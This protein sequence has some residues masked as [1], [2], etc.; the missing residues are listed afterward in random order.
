MRKSVFVIFAF[1]F[2]V[3][4]SGLP[5]FR[6]GF[7]QNYHARDTVAVHAQSAGCEAYASSWPQVAHDP[8]HT[9]YIDEELI[10]TNPSSPSFTVKWVHAFQP[11]KVYPQVQPI[12]YCGKV[13]VGTEGANG[14]KPTVYAFDAMSVGKNMK[15]TFET[16]GPIMASAAGANGVVVIADMSGTVYGLNAETGSKLWEQ[17]L[18]DRH[19]FS[20]SPVISD[21]SIMIG[22][23]NG[24]LYVL[25]LDG[26]IPSGWQDGLDLHTPLLQTPAYANG[27]LYIG[28]MDLKMYAIRIA[29]KSIVWESA[30]M[31]GIALNDYWPIITNNQL[32]IRPTPE[33][34]FY[35]V[36]QVGG[37]FTWGTSQAWLDQYATTLAAGNLLD[38]PAANNAQTTF[39]ANV[40][41]NPNS[42]ANN[43]YVLDISDG[44]IAT[45][46]PFWNQALNGANPP[47]CYDGLNDYLVTPVTF[48]RGTFG[49]LD[50]ASRKIVDILFDNKDYNGNLLTAT[51]EPAGSG[52]MDET[53]LCSVSK[54]LVFTL[55]TQEANA[56]YTGAFDL[57]NRR[58]IKMPAGHTDAAMRSN[59]QG[60][61]G[62][63]ASIAGGKIYH[64]SLNNLIVR[65]PQ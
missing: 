44:S 26:T 56:Y 48:I 63:P 24:R 25:N 16:L 34:I 59:T 27:V 37:P 10:F 45:R 4:I 33:E 5:Y 47:P 53:V 31:Q 19:G 49:R 13:I 14:Q 46:V 3:F 61:G 43:F 64:L 55:H 20:A 42:F 52:N 8:Q 36:S 23:R 1:L 39:L 65:S 40:D 9:G 6:E 30:R 7:F 32:V 11:D 50:L 22:G 57:T 54:N 15:W 2:A 62:S 29:D 60:A 41:A 17:K 28:G 12:V 35:G 18:M 21:G 58:W 51:A 38:I